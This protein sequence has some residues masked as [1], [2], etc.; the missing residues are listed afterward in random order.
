MRAIYSLSLSITS[1]VITESKFHK[2]HIV[3]YQVIY[4]T[5]I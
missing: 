4:P 5:L 3:L 2:S 1:I